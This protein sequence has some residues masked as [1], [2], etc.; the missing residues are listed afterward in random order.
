MSEK[1]IIDLT[2]RIKHISNHLETNRKDYSTQRG[3]MKLV[4]QRKSL[5]N[6]LKKNNVSSYRTLIQNIKNK[7]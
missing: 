1:Q 4:G 6:Y 3:M 7:K 2:E 5:L